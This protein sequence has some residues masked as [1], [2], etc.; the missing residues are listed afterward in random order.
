M[1][2]IQDNFKEI[3]VK[4]VIKYD[5][6]QISIYRID[7][8]HG[9]FSRSNDK[10]SILCEKIND[11]S[12][13]EQK[14]KS[15]FNNDYVI[16][17]FYKKCP[18]KPKWKLFLKDVVESDQ[19]I[20]KEN[21]SWSES[22]VMIFLSLSSQNL[23]AVTGGLGY[24]AVKEIIDDDFGVGILSRLVSKDDKI[25]KSV[26]EKSVMGG[27][28]GA[29]KFFRKNYNLFE[30]DSFG[31]IYQE[32]KFE[33]NNDILKDKFGFSK[34]KL[35]KNSSCIAKTSFKINKSIAFDQIFEIINGCENIYNDETLKPI[36]INNVKKISKKKN[37]DLIKKLEKELFVQLWKR[38]SKESDSCEFDI[39][40]QDFENYLMASTYIIKKNDCKS[41]FLG[42]F[43]FANLENIDELFDE[44]KKLEEKPN[45]QED[46]FKLIESL[47]IFSYGEEDVNNPLTKGLVL[48]HIFGDIV[49]ENCKYFLIDNNWFNIKDEFIKELNKSCESFIN[50]NYNENLEKKWNYPS[51]KENDFNAKF[52][53]N[54]PKN[55]KVLVLDKIIPENIEPCDILKWDEQCIYFYHVKAGFGN[56]MRDLCSQIF[57]AANKIKNDINASKEYIGKIYNGLANKKNSN[58]NYYKKA[59]NQT[60]HITKN[61]FVNLFDKRKLVFVLAVL[62][63]GND[64][65]LKNNLDSFNSNI[66]KFSLQ[67]LIKGMKGIDVELQFTQIFKK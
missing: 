67:E 54:N 52:I 46:F 55:D 53:S 5:K 25:L 8:D 41:N 14:L 39:C 35:S 47:K 44:I 36:S 20:L 30:N 2:N 22:F 57:V 18:L 15:N 34:D 45:N 6:T 17:L 23:Y 60:N 51:E 19:D 65:S 37:Q 28:L 62:D 43:E 49:F 3:S 48:H 33:L 9:L 10:I 66:A 4:N 27:V 38:F 32:L 50:K 21:Q 12:F 16:K 24:H 13:K 63:T 59:G 58:D 64:R 26:K 61:E 40:H 1:Y 11:N 56:A 42:D 29:I 7:T 31:K